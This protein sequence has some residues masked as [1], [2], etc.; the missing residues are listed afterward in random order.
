MPELPL[1]LHSR[2]EFMH[3]EAVA[4][5]T[6]ALLWLGEER[7]EENEREEEGSLLPQPCPVR[8]YRADIVAWCV[9]HV[10]Y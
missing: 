2:Q 8:V 5:A 1:S 4:A 9:P 3:R 6:S 10:S 7:Q